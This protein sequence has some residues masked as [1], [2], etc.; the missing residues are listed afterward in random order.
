MPRFFVSFGQ[1]H[2]HRINGKTFDCDVLMELVEPDYNTAYERAH[3]LT[4]GIFGTV[5]TEEQ[6]QKPGFM[7]LFPNGSMPL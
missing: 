2:T 6:A 4:G 5:Y 7:E 3:E 1:V